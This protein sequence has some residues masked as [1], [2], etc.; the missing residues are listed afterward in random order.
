MSYT[1]KSNID[2]L[3]EEGA[4]FLDSESDSDF[5]ENKIPENPKIKFIKN[6]TTPKSQGYETITHD[7]V[8]S[9]D[10]INETFNELLINPDT[11]RP[12]FD[13]DGFVPGKQAHE[14][15]PEQHIKNYEEYKQLIKWLDE[16]ASKD[17]GKYSLCGYTKDKSMSKMFG[18]K[19]NPKNPHFVS[20][21]VVFYT[22]KI[23]PDVLLKWIESHKSSCPFLDDD[24]YK[25]KS[26]QAFRH[27]MSD[28]LIGN[29]LTITS[30]SIYGNLPPE[31]QII[32]PK[33]NERMFK[34]KPDIDV[35]METKTKRKSFE[36]KPK[37][38]VEDEYEAST[39]IINVS[40]DELNDILTNFEP[41]YSSGLEKLVNCVLCAP[42]R[43]E[44]M[45]RECLTD[46]YMSIEHENGITTL[47]TFYNHYRKPEETNKWIFTLV[48]HIPN[49]QL[50]KDWK[51]FYVEKLKVLEG[52][53]VSVEFDPTQPIE[54]LNSAE[55]NKAKDINDKTL[56]LCRGVRNLQNM[57]CWMIKISNG[58]VMFKNEESLKRFLRGYIKGSKNVKQVYEELCIKAKN[59]TITSLSFSNIFTGWRFGKCKSENYDENVRLWCECIKTNTFGQSPEAF[60]YIMKR[61]SFILNNPGKLSKVC[62]VLKGIEGTGKNFYCDCMAKLTEGYSNPNAEL[63]KITGKFNGSVY[64]KAYVVANEALESNNKL[65]QLE[66]IKKLVERPTLDIERKGLE[67]FQGE[68]AV[69]LDITS[70][71]VKPVLISPTDRRFCVIKSSPVHANDRE[72]WQF[73]QEELINREG[74]YDDLFIHITSI[75]SDDFLSDQIPGT[76]ERYRLILASLNPVMKFIYTHLSEFAEGVSKDWIKENWNADNEVKTKYSRDGFLNAV[77]DA[78]ERVPMTHGEYKGRIRFFVNDATYEALL[79]LQERFADDDKEEEPEFTPPDE[80]E[81]EKQE[82]EENLEE[83]THEAEGFKYILSAE[84]PKGKRKFVEDYLKTHD[85]TFRTALSRKITKRGWKHSI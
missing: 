3:I 73:Y 1:L 26:R 63:S 21:H 27:G 74:F 46:W 17:F 58:D 41:R 44:D 60:D 75:P 12:Y 78:C 9:Y 18:L 29:E 69:N 28:K 34:E 10:F 37:H 51:D 59:E 19:Y 5:N 76:E 38:E 61:M 72:Y 62:L 65:E 6:L 8:N 13:F 56:A 45:I 20:V 2:A 66:A 39:E 85:W 70:N 64:S 33:G 79:K 11:V 82:L 50:R 68:N 23:K 40:S 81:K 80:L 84:I 4:E 48:K 32:T 35:L 71:N 31:T 47:E 83:L 52:L 16:V 67:A 57:D 7:E 30:G 36:P 77:I 49:E 25:L 55:I 53:T 24:V 54:C 22:V 42:L 43:F 15:H 14:A